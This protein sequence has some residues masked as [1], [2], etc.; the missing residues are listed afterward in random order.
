MAYSNFSRT[1]V[2]FEFWLKFFLYSFCG[3]WKNKVLRWDLRIS[4]FKSEFI[5]CPSG[6]L[7][8]LGLPSWLRP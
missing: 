6:F 3:F 2:C 8:Q 4:L 1:P 7:Q 5:S